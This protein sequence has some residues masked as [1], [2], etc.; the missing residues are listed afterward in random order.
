[1]SERKVISAKISTRSLEGWRTFCMKNGVS[2]TA[3]I[4]VAGLQ[5]AEESH[6]PTVQARVRMVEDARKVDIE[7]RTRSA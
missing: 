5:L 3:L 4:E 6:P 2:L 1:M 7:R